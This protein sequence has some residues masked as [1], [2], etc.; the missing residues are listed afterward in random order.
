MGPQALSVSYCVESSRPQELSRPGPH[1]PVLPSAGH[2]LSCGSGKRGRRE[3][4]WLSCGCLGSARAQEPLH[5]GAPLL[6]QPFPPPPPPN[7]VSS[8]DIMSHVLHH[9]V[10]VSVRGQLTSS[11]L[12][13]GIQSSLALQNYTARILAA[14]VRRGR[15]CRRPGL[16]RPLPRTPTRASKLSGNCSSDLHGETEAALPAGVPPPLGLRKPQRSPW[17]PCL[18]GLGRGERKWR[19]EA[20]VFPQQRNSFL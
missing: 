12:L 3:Q 11:A 15:V 8:Q 20:F 9:G 4:T 16:H 1:W 17:P 13:L 2:H 5:S 7:T 10:L 6:P 19:W 18:Y 14:A